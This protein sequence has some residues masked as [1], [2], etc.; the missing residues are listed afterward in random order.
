MSA[1]RVK[2]R[3]DETA[4]HR[5]RQSD[6]WRES[7][8]H[9]GATHSEGI[10]LGLA[11]ST[12]LSL[13]SF[14][15]PYTDES[16]TEGKGDGKELC[17]L[18]VVFGDDVLIFSDKECEYVANADPKVAWQ[19]W[20]KRAILKSAK[21]VAGAESWIRRF[22]G[23]VF[24]DAGCET[25]LPVELPN[26]SRMR[27]HRV[28]VCR[29]SARASQ[30]H[31][32]QLGKGSSSSLILDSQVES[33]AHL[34]HP[35][36]VG[37]PLGRGK[38]VHVLDELTL[39]VVLGELNTAPDFIRY[40]RAKEAW[41]SNCGADV[42]VLGEEDLVVTYLFGMLEENSESPF[43]AVPAGGLLM[44]AEGL[45]K[46]YASGGRR[47]S[48]RKAEEP[49]YVW[50][51]LIEFQSAHIIGGTAYTHMGENSVSEME[52]V[53][54]AMAE[55]DRAS[56]QVLGQSLLRVARPPST[57]MRATRLA[58]PQ[59]GLK[60][61]YA[62]LSLPRFKDQSFEDYREVRQY[63]LS[64]YCEGCKLR[65]P[66]VR[67]LIGIAIEPDPATAVSVDFMFVDFGSKPL[68]PA[69]EQEMRQR[70]EEEEMWREPHI[71]TLSSTP[72]PT[73]LSRLVNCVTGAATAFVKA[74]RKR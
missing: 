34:S 70:V 37:W 30:R 12:F 5:G 71:T 52:R 39:E 74:P 31:W 56:R 17:D 25:P 53:Q 64:V 20:Y 27:I 47:R 49:S 54:R 19:R 2:A 1:S 50:D 41:F 35:F 9:R 62:F 66:E 61:A 24:L 6:V 28:V 33:D 26:P 60:R 48:K 8:S 46:K 32:D 3:L 58:L 57:R 45:W 51:D 21:Q 43:P 68:D 7:A 29:G 38:Y 59:G 11:R 22:P 14:A 44:H 40:L 18:L 55:E 69:L 13:W 42:L 16:R 4:S 36:V 23:R 67:E 63:Q 73:V 65:F 15:N 72:S 10:V